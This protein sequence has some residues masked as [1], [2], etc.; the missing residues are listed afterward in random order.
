[1]LAAPRG[2][3]AKPPD[4][5][6]EDNERTGVFPKLQNAQEVDVKTTP[7]VSLPKM[8]YDSDMSSMDMEFLPPPPPPFFFPFEK[9]FWEPM[10]PFNV[11]PS[12]Y[13]F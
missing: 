12:R 11:I 13:P 4:S 3:V 6:V 5:Y 2:G 1:M 7:A 8:Y 9:V 10:V